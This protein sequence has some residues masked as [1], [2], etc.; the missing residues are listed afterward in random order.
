MYADLHLHT[1]ASD[2]ILTP[3]EVV[4]AAKEKGLSAIAITDH[5][6]TSGLEEALAEGKR[7]GLEVLPGIELSTLSGE[8]E[9]HILGYLNEWNSKTLQGILSK[10]IESRQNRAHKIIEK[11]N[12]LGLEIQL[13]NVEEIAGAEFVGRPHIARAMQKKGY[14]KDIK[15]A[16]TVDYI[17]RGGRAY[18]ERFIISPEESIKTLLSIGAIPVLAHPGYLSQG[19]PISEEEIALLKSRG[20]RGIEVY[21]NMHN[22][23]QTVLYKSIAEKYNLL[24]TGGSDCHGYEDE[25]NRIGSLKLPYK[26]VEALKKSI[27]G[28]II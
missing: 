8:R 28:S 18:V 17:G 9:I 27:S 23:E 6:T 25:L 26:Y 22:P 2:G 15:E 7:I 13:A 11:L 14:I 24:L 10:I 1:T 16:F 4:F 3:T 21:Y 20:L 5:D 19:K 12:L